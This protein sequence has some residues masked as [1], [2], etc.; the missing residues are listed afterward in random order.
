MTHPYPLADCVARSPLAGY[1][2]SAPPA[3][4]PVAWSAIALADSNQAAAEVACRWLIETQAADGSVGVNRNEASPAWPTALA[5]YAWTKV[6][7]QAYALPIQKA[8]AWALDEHGVPMHGGELVRHDTSL[9]GWSWAPATHSWLEPTA[10]FV[11]ALTTVGCQYHARVEEGVRLLTDRLLPDG[12]AN[13]GNTIVLGQTLLPHVQPSGIAMWAL[14]D[15]PTDDQRVERTLNFLEKSLAP[16]L[17]SAS[18]AFAA[19]GLSAHHRSLDQLR[20]LLESAAERLASSGASPYR[21]AL[22]LAAL[23]A[24]TESEST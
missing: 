23:N 4:E 14:A 11:K 7:R 8:V 15:R 16:D 22:V 12:G 10:F 13:Y 24:V 21:R 18:L 2:D 19:I 9:I 5:L 20:P 6:D 17:A 1:A 3:S